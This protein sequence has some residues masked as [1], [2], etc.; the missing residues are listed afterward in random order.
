MQPQNTQLIPARPVHLCWGLL[1][2]GLARQM[3][4]RTA[5]RAGTL[6]QRAA[7][8]LLRRRQ[9]RCLLGVAGC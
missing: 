7:E 2:T 3:L 4:R 9:R 5:W 8:G 6:R 1:R